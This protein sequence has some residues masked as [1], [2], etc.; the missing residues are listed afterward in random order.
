MTNRDGSLATTS[1]PA[2]E[3][4]AAIARALYDLGPTPVMACKAD[5]RFSYCLYVPPHLGKSTQPPELIVAMHGTGRG[6]TGYRDGFQDFARWN[7][8]IVLAPLFPIGV[9]GDDNRDGFKYMREGEIRYDMVL[10][11]MVAEVEARYGVS[12]PRFALFGYSGGGHFAHRFLMLQPRRL[13]ACSIGAPGSVT[14]LDPTRDWWVGTRNM[15]ELFGAAPDIAAMKQVAVQM[16]VG[17][18]DLETWEITHKPGGRNWMPDANHAGR[19]RPERLASLKA[20]FEQAGIP[21]RFDLVANM[22]HDGLRA[23]P[24]VEDFFAEHLTALRAAAARAA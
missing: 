15:A 19:T 23:V 22:A 10:L 9:L 11:A 6:F 21:V 16:I 4:A 8:C 17:A 1:N 24:K 18:A 3:D 5:P 13:W 2:S 12:F 20:S 7:N 14:L